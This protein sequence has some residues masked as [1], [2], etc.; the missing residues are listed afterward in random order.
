[1]DLKEAAVVTFIWGL[2]SI[3]NRFY[4]TE[5]AFIVSMTI[6]KMCAQN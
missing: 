5:S 1:M 4:P 6:Y 2:L 3:M